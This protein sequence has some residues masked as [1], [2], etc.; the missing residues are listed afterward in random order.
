MY[1]RPLETDGVES[2]SKIL[3]L[4]EFVLSS[5]FLFRE[6]KNKSHEMS[7]IKPT[8]PITLIMSTAIKKSWEL[9]N[10]NI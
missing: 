2:L 10:R 1:V 4:Q 6:K 9:I 7:S 3:L 8:Y 5:Q